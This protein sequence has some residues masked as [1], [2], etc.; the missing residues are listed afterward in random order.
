MKYQV[1]IEC[2]NNKFDLVTTKKIVTEI[3][4]D[5]AYMETWLIKE[6]AR[7]EEN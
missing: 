4:N 5:E 6:N 7:A 1:R 3:S 2:K